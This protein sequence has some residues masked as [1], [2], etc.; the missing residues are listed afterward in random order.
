MMAAMASGL[1]V[2][3]VVAPPRGARVYAPP[4]VVVERPERHWRWTRWPHYEVENRYVVESRP[5]IVRERQYYP[6]YARRYPYVRKDKG[7][8]KGWYKRYD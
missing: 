1:L 5:V 6:Y 3:C 7:K 8:H 2:G 4:G